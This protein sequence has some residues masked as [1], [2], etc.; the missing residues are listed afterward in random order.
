MCKGGRGEDSGAGNRTGHGTL[1][2]K[3]P[4]YSVRAGTAHA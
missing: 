1:L 3:D 4:M 2:H